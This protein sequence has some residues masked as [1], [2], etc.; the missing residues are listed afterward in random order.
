M[1][2]PARFVTNIPLPSIIR[3]SSPTSVCAYLAYVHTRRKRVRHMFLQFWSADHCEI[4]SDKVRHH[5][6]NRP[7][8]SLKFIIRRSASWSDR[9]TKVVPS[10]YSLNILILQT[11]ERHS[12]SV[13]LYFRSVSVIVLLQNPTIYHCFSSLR[14]LSYYTYLLASVSIMKGR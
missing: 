7:C 9:T 6:S 3:S 5:R 4:T 10:V 13:S 11:N 8:G 1:S 2:F 12:L 14:F